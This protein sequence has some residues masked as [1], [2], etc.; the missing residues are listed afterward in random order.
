MTAPHLALIWAQARPADG[1]GAVIGRDGGM[2]WHLPEDLAHFRAL[3]TGRP[4]IMGRSTWE[5]LPPRFRPLPGRANIVLTRRAGATFAGAAVAADVDSAVALAGALTPGTAWV[6]GGAQLYAAT[7]ARA[8]RL[9]VTELDLTLEPA[10]G[11]VRAPEIGDHWRVVATEPAAVGPAPAWH[12]S[13]TGLR[14]RFVSYERA[15]A[16]G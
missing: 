11:D 16:A 1:G 7:I 13:S 14:Y 10:A 5:S 6:I 9:E 8:D 15:T 2:P 4:V 3:T 12:T